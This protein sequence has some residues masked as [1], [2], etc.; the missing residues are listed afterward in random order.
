MGPNLLN[1]LCTVTQT[2]SRQMTAILLIPG[3]V[4]AVFLVPMSGWNERKPDQS[5]W[6]HSW[7]PAI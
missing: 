6:A 4:I 2:A 5:T 3:A 7:L 1:G